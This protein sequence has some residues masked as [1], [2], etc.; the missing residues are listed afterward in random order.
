MRLT[1]KRIRDAKPGAK[2]YILRD[3]DVIGLGFR[4]TPA[5]AK[6][7][8]L[9]YRVA[10]KRRLL[11][12]ARAGEI[13]L[14]EARQR[15]G[16]ELAAIRDGATDP[17]RRRQEAR[18][19]PTFADLWE[20]FE[21]EFAPERI[22][23]GRMTPNTLQNYRKQARRYLLPAFGGQRITDLSRADVDRMAR[24]MAHAP[25]QR[26]RTLALASR[27]FT[28][29]ETW[30]WRPQNTNPVKGVMR[31]REEARDRT[32]SGGE[33]AALGG[34][35]DSLAERYQAAVAAIRV[36]ALSGMRIGEVIGMEWPM[37]DFERGSVTLPE[38]KTGRQVRVLPSAVLE[39]LADM[40]RIHGCDAV[41]TATGRT[42]I[43][44]RYV[45][46]V[47]AEACERAG[48][49][50]V[51]LHDLRRTVATNAAAAGI[52][53]TL[54]R[55]VLGHST[56]AMSARYVRRAGGALTDAVENSGAAMAAAMSGKAGKVIPMR[57]NAAK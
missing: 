42:P 15:A 43:R 51:R 10:G 6:A 21:T 12:L 18:E 4:V 16:R 13:S 23:L 55:D 35:L 47:F 33:L 41:F 17:L 48:L 39:L 30:E 54:L 50:G 3:D 9:D 27:L 40:P 20:R 24:R 22:S 34:A 8:V 2:T 38:T 11:T 56:I 29:A 7:Y 36:A 52:G 37:I 45:R 14:A 26:N 44:Y 5:G 31:A 49:D 25:A 19:A 46:V 32:L 53:V 57:R 28:L 1:E